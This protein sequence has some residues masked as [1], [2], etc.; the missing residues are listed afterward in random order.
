MRIILATGIF[1]PDIGGPATYVRGVARELTARGDSVTVITYGAQ[2]GY[3]KPEGYA[4]VSVG[5]HG[6][7]LARWMRYR[8]ELIAHGKDA[9]YVCAFTSISAGV[10]LLLSSLKTPTKVLRLGGDFFWERYTDAGGTKT[11]RQWYASR[12]SFWR[13]VNALIM[14]RVLRS[15]DRLVYSTEFQRDIHLSVYHRL[16][17]SSVESN[18]QPES[19]LVYHERHSPFRLLFMGRFVRFKNIASLIDAMKLLPDTTLTIVGEGP[20][21]T[22]LKNRVMQ[23]G[24]GDRVSFRPSVSGDEKRRLFDE[25][26]L[27]VLPSLTEISPNT[28]LEA[29]SVCLPVLL[30]EETGLPEIPDIIR[31]TLKTPEEIATAIRDVME[32]YPSP[33]AEESLRTYQKISDALFPPISR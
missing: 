32:H 9:D 11:L 25:H 1:P 20:L 7:P 29:R 10:P 33:K 8:K 4:V 5:K 6:G 12:F 27:L 17:L 16:P 26:D 13:M 19:V 3:E 18:A 24:V 14:G 22:E 31:R 30:T 2:Q 21:E 23:A 15:F 28:A